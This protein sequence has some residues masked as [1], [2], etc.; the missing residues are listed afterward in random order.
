MIGRVILA[1]L[2]SGIAAGLVMGVIQ[3]VRLTPL[4]LEAEA[5]ER[6]GSP[7]GHSHDAAAPQPGQPDGD[8]QGHDHEHDHGEGWTPETGWQRTLATTVTAAMTGAGFAAILAGLSLLAG[9]RIT[10]RNGIIW[11]LCGFLAVTLAPA[12]GLPPELPG[13]AAADL[14][15]RQVWWA[16]AVAATAAGIYLI[17]TQ[18]R[19]FV[20]V[21]AALLI[22]APHIVGAPV[23][24]HGEN[25]IPAELIARFVASSIAANAVL[26]SVIGLLLGLVLDHTAKDIYA[27]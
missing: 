3:H 7:A 1:V 11:G 25:L 18:K 27:T 6:A 15:S 21:L 17:A 5:F 16:G 14:F 4:I 10:R 22:L 13:M 12:A 2:L 9:L 8:G 20:M 19:V 23:A 26:W 24:P